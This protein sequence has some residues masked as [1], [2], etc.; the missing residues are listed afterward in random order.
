MNVTPLWHIQPLGNDFV[1]V[2]D[3]QPVPTAPSRIQGK[4]HQSSAD[5]VFAI[6]LGLIGAIA[7]VAVLCK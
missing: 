2:Y 1:V 5:V 6:V 3:G 4:P 7:L